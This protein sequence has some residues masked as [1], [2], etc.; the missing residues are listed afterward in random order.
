[1]KS[2]V[3]LRMEG[4]CLS[5]RAG[6]QVSLALCLLLLIFPSGLGAQGLSGVTGTITDQ[7]GAVV[8][9]AKITL[10]NVATGVK[11][12]ATTTGAGTYTITDLIPGA[13][14]ARVEKQGFATRVTTGVYVDVS[15]TTTVDADLSMGT[16]TET[17]EVTIPEISLETTQP[18]LGTVIENKITEE[19]P[20]IIG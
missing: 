9:G 13:Y 10:T 1:M 12:Y 19:V 18:Q 6:L 20:V 4:I 5:I 14:S 8:P 16:A 2:F 3:I 11:S 15:R 7:T 17:I